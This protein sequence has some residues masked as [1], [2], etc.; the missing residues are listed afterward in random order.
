MEPDRAAALAAAGRPVLVTGGAG[1]L[2]VAVVRRLRAAGHPVAVLDDGSA[3]TQGRLRAFAG[4]A[5][6]SHHRA[7]I[8]DADAVAELHRGVRPWAV[9][10][11]AAKHFI[12]DC[13]RDPQETGWVN[14]AGTASVLAAWRAHRPERFVFASSAA[15]YAD[16]AGRLSERSRLA[17]GTVYGRTKLAGERMVHRHAAR[18]GVGALSVRLFNLYGRGPTADHLIPT[19]LA[20]AR[21][22][23][24]LRLGDLRTVRDY[25]YVEDAADAVVALLA[26]GATGAV[27]IGTGRGTAGREV[28]ASI[29]DILGV[30][31]TAA[32]DPART[33][34]WDSPA[35]VAD[36]GRLRA[37][38]PAWRPVP[39]RE[40][41]LRTTRRAAV[42]P[43]RGAVSRGHRTAPGPAAAARSAA[44]AGAR[45]A[46]RPAAPRPPAG[47]G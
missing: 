35:V 21:A 39:L 9:V 19:V 15:V 11:L 37:L 23:G 10:H 27:N 13:E 7:S 16:S 6:V 3:G 17:P 32:L 1:F 38:L 5:G 36:V 20:Q 33:R 2:G 24:A 43:R 31:G 42:E 18:S 8:C 26:G 22:G 4:D 30:A 47:A 40:G 46:A 29:L 44:P 34:A 28:V 12:P 14:T 41:L 25:V 45:A